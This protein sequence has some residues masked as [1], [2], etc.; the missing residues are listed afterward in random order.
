MHKCVPCRY[1]YTCKEAFAAATRTLLFPGVFAF[2]LPL[3]RALRDAPV[4]TPRPVALELSPLPAAA[5]ARGPP[6]LPRSAPASLLF[7]TLDCCSSATRAAL[8][9]RPWWPPE[10]PAAAFLALLLV[11]FASAYPRG[12]D[13]AGRGSQSVGPSGAAPRAA[14]C[15]RRAAWSRQD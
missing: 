15:P 11:L 1:Y 9:D 4:P 2:K 14:F 7:S 6:E 8:L 3:R 12:D 10:L 5:P 13:E